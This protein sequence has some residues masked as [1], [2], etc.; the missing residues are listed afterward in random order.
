MDT[1]TK[2][3]QTDTLQPK[4]VE[5]EVYLCGDCDYVADCVHDFND[6][7]H[8][9]HGLEDEDNSIFNCNFRSFET[10][11]EVMMHNKT[12]HHGCVQHCKQ[13]LN[14]ICY[15]GNNCWFLHSESLRNSEPSLIC[16]FC[17]QKF[18]TQNG[19]REHMKLLHIQNVPHCKSEN[20]DQ[21]N[22]GLFT[23]KT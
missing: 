14:G 11:Q 4:T 19:V 8:N 1:D 2:E 20:L 16:N 18:K 21:E 13:F 6:H 7:T 10:L 3:I 22:V 23:R 5:I 17:D 15:F 9:L 12:I